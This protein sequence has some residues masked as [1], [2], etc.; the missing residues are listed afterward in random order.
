[1]A[2]KEAE[3]DNMEEENED[4]EDETSSI[5]ARLRLSVSSLL[6]SLPFDSVMADK[7]D[8]EDDDE[9]EEEDVEKN[10]EIVREWEEGVRLRE[11]I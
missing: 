7:D 2:G 8:D 1:M 4:E 10:A 5:F 9:E 3:E 11:R 6:S